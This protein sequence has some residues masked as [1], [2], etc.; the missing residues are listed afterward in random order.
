M[1][2]QSID[3]EIGVN[4]L[5]LVLCCLNTEVGTSLARMSTVCSVVGTYLS[6]RKR[7]PI[8]NQN[9]VHFKLLGLI[10]PSG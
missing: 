2:T 10:N 3:A 7:A 8:F 1:L 6:G 9:V 4:K 5:R